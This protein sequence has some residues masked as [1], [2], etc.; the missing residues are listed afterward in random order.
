MVWSRVRTFALT[1]PKSGSQFAKNGQEPDRTGLRQHYS[2]TNTGS[3][4]LKIFREVD[5]T[6]L[7]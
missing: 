7:E 6:L 1:E 4:I 3:Q 2:E 5:K